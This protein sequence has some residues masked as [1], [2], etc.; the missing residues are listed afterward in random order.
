MEEVTLVLVLSKIHFSTFTF[1]PIHSRIFWVP[2]IPINLSFT[3]S[4]SPIPGSFYST[5]IITLKTLYELQNTTLKVIFILLLRT[6]TTLDI[7]NMFYIV[8]FLFDTQVLKFLFTCNTRELP[9]VMVQKETRMT[10]N[11]I[12]VCFK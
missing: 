11:N 1:D 5:F 8:Y 4:T 3:Y 2:A 10:T 9:H 12:T 6:E 7:N